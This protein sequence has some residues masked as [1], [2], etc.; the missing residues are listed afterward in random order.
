MDQKINYTQSIQ[1]WFENHQPV[2]LIIA[3]KWMGRPYDNQYQLVQLIIQKNNIQLNLSDELLLD[4]EYFSSMQF[5][6]ELLLIQ[7]VQNLTLT[8]LTDSFFE[9]KFTNVSVQFIILKNKI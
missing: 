4:F 2:G 6:D 5:S 7:G 9:K 8:S 3:N 1:N